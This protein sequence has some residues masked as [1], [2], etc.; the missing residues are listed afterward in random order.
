MKTAY[1]ILWIDDEPKSTD[2]DQED[3][4]DFLEEVGIRA[5]ISF[6]EAPEDGS[7]RER[8]EHHL[9]D[10]DLDLL[11]VD[12]HMVGLQGDQL[13]RLIRETDHIYLP[14][15][16]YSSSSVSD[17]LDAVRAAELDGVYIANRTALIQKVRSVVGSLLVREQTVKQVRGLLMEGVS[18]IDAQFYEIFLR[19]WPKLDADQQAQ[20]GKYV[21][22]IVDERAKSAAKK[23]ESFPLDAETLGGHLTEKLLT[24]AYDTHTRWRLTRKILDISG[25]AED[26]IGELKKF[27]EV[28]DGEVPLNTLR[29]DYAHKSRKLLSESHDLDRCIKIRKSLRTQSANIDAIL[30]SE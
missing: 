27:A 28:E 22:M 24:A 9:K 29:N 17:L 21:K 15:I 13:V 3:V 30:G 19:I 8:L 10:P 14:V 2:T 18:E 16:F 7:I 25:H 12:Y 4:K 26:Y 11:M 1:H 23:A 20:V 5:D 6:V